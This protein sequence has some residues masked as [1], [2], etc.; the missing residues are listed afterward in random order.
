MK[1]IFNYVLIVG[2]ISAINACQK[3]DVPVIDVD[4][5]VITD[6]TP[7]EPIE[8]IPAIGEVTSA[9]PIELTRKQQER[10]N[11]DNRFAFRM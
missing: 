6:I 4:V 2:L 7:E 8:E 3:E 1:K 9:A 5:P 10:T 11:I